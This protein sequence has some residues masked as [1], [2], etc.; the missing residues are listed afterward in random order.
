MGCD[1][2]W[3][4]GT[5]RSDIAWNKRKR[6]PI[7]SILCH[8]DAISRQIVCRLAGEVDGW[9]GVEMHLFL[10]WPSGAPGASLTASHRSTM[11]TWV[12]SFAVRNKK[13]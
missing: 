12:T 10:E 13:P 2:W 8:Y 9:V 7:I 1:I 6:M 11:M 3:D 4:K 5:E